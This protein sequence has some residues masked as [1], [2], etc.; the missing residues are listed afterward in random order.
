MSFSTT[1][2]SWELTARKAGGSGIIHEGAVLQYLDKESR[3][4]PMT[5][6]RVKP[7]VQIS[8]CICTDEP[9]PR[10]HQGAKSVS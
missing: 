2:L 10:S 3:A 7:R 6:K 5:A 9:G 1:E 4:D 8:K